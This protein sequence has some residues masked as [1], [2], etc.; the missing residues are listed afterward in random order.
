MT[1]QISW[2]RAGGAM[3]FAALLGVAVSGQAAD[4]TP[5]TLAPAACASLK[6]MAIPAAA[7]GLPT[8]GADVQA[9]EM[10][11]ANAEKNVNGD[12]CKVTGVI[13]NATAS[14]A[15]FE[16]E[17]NLPARWNGRALQMGGGGYDGSL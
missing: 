2:L 10:V 11:A 13:K 5:V 7:I 4:D 16:F 12:F 15:V 3:C 1:K 6:G 9:A 8:G 14:T 17:V